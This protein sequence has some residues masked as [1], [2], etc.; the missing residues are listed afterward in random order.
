MFHRALTPLLTH[1]HS[2]IHSFQMLPRN[3]L[4]TGDLPMRKTGSLSLL[5]PLEEAGAGL[6]DDH[7]DKNMI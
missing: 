4:H 6:H 2:F 5:T 3:S 1:D 7:T